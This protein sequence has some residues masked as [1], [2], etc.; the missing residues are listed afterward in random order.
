MEGVFEIHCTVRLKHSKTLNTFLAGIKLGNL[1]IGYK[2]PKYL[3]MEHCHNII[4]TMYMYTRW[5]HRTVLSNL[6]F[7]SDV[8]Q[9]SNKK[10]VSFIPPLQVVNVVM[11]P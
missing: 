10:T 7:Y 2:Q 9:T 6:N 4:P 3:N 5:Y 8:R 11:V 1:V